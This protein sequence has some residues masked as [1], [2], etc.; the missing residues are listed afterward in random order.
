[1]NARIGV[2]SAVRSAVLQVPPTVEFVADAHIPGRPADEDVARRMREQQSA[3]LL[4]VV[5]RVVSA[6][7]HLVSPQP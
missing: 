5:A 3:A 6:R 2:R 4:H 1:M 7:S